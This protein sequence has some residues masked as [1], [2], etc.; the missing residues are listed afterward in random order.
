MKK[1][2]LIGS[3]LILPLAV[4]L[5]AQSAAPS[6]PNKNVVL[7]I[8][9]DQGLDLG[10]YGNPVIQTPNQ[11]RLAA[12]GVRFT[13]AFATVASCSPSRSVMFT[14]LFN[15]TSG[16]YGLSHDYHN[17]HAQPRVQSLPALLKEAGYRTGIVGKFHVKPESYYP[18][19]Y[20]V[21][22]GQ[23]GGNRDVARMAEKAKEFFTEDPDTPFYLH[24]GFSDPHRAGSGFA[25]ERD[26]QGIQRIRYS[27][28]DIV[29]PSHLPD[30][31]EARQEMAE[32]YE[33]VSRLDQGIGLILEAL[34]A[35]GRDGDTL[36]IFVSDNGIPFPGA[37]TTLYEPGV[38]LPMIV[39]SPE[40]SRRGLVNHAMVSFIDL[41]PTILDWTGAPG[42]TYELPGRSILP[43]LEQENAEGW[44]EVF[45]SHTFHEVTM[46]YPVRAVRTRKHKYI[47]NLFPEL[48]YPFPS[49]L[50]ASATWQSILKGKL[51]HMGSRRVEDYLHRP[52]EELYDLEN[53]PDEVK[54]LAADARYAPILRDLRGRL[55]DFQNRTDDPWNKRVREMGKVPYGSEG[56]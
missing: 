14:G 40:P 3:L 33:S 12:R 29:L 38:H 27:P 46:Y 23:L 48:T 5:V 56:F 55:D 43:I 15:H 16:Q 7:L 18:F 24:V 20:L 19:D 34:E 35:T 6:Q 49:D 8:A 21:G 51:T 50:W 1:S 53:D 31:P 26:Y 45:L 37:K 54:N 42:P 52:A 25:N 41:V 4:W 22:G 47:K 9:D 2:L 13:H 10:C 39:S 11:D 17:F 32:Y 30:T 44:D 28:S 36:V